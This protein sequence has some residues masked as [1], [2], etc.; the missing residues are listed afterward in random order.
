MVVL[1][2]LAIPLAQPLSALAQIDRTKHLASPTNECCHLTAAFEGLGGVSLA[3]QEFF[4]AVVQSDL[5]RVWGAVL[6]VVEVVSQFSLGHLQLGDFKALRI[7][8]PARRTTA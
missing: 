1:G 3:L 6:K 7:S 5:V 4:H 8:L 2:N